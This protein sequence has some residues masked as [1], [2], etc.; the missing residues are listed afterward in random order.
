MTARVRAGEIIFNAVSPNVQS[1]PAESARLPAQPRRSGLR[2]AGEGAEVGTQRATLFFFPQGYV[3]AG[4]SWLHGGG[5][6]IPPWATPPAP[7]RG[8]PRL[9]QAAFPSEMSPV[10]QI[11]SPRWLCS[12]VGPWPQP[13]SGAITVVDVTKRCQPGRALAVSPPE[14]ESSEAGAEAKPACFLRCGRNGGFG[15]F[16]T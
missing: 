14:E 6:S 16:L 2:I 3:C 15:L 1:A 4:T 9:P 13:I 11:P 8:H 7:R 5:W 10:L 12:G